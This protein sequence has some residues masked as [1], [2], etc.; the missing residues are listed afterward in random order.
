MGITAGRVPGFLSLF[1]AEG[2]QVAAE[3]T[4]RIQGIAKLMLGVYKLQ[5]SLLECRSE[6]RTDMASR[7]LNVDIGCLN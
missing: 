3:A 5:G 1:K 6:A 2:A 7:G 4:P